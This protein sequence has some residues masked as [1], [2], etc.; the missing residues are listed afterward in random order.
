MTARPLSE[1][2]EEAFVQAR[3]MDASLADRL[4]SFADSVRKLGPVFQTSV[5]G[6]VARLREHEVGENAPKPGE[7]MPNFVLPNQNASLISLEGL[8]EKGPVAVTFHRGHWCPYCRINT[9]VLA[10]AQDQIAAAG[11]QIV[12]IMPDRQH[13]AVELEEQSGSSFPI[14]TDFDNGYAL[15]LNLAFWVGE[16][17]RELMTRAGWD[18][19][20]SQGSD[21]WLLPVPATFVVG[22]DGRV[23][24]RFVDPDY[25]KRMAVEDLLA[26][27][28]SAG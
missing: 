7:P 6:L 27:L 4:Q 25:R 5:D 12:A 26:A 11:G 16:E 1:Q 8:L 28:D 14:L 20:P 19:A 9:K 24:A 23:N 3:D 21:A 2:L 10:E 15:S 13:Y 18:V 17:M 22:T